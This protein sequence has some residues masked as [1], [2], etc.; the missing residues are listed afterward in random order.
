MSLHISHLDADV[1]AATTAVV[2][3]AKHATPLAESRPFSFL[4]SALY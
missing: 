4:P 2:V 3:A 1:V